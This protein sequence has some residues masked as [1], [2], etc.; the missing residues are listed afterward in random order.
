MERR[1]LEGFPS[2]CRC[3]RRVIR[4]QVCLVLLRGITFAIL[5]LAIAASSCLHWILTGP[6]GIV[7][8]YYCFIQVYS[9]PHVA[10]DLCLCS[11]IMMYRNVEGLLHH[12]YTCIALRRAVAHTSTAIA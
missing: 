5:K 12:S 10:V 7:L 4:G 6:A 3:K 2:M 8:Q 1:S 11:A 9:H